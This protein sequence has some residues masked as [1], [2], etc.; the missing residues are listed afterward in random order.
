M[1]DDQRSLD[2]RCTSGA[3]LIRSISNIVVGDLFAR[4]QIAGCP[5]PNVSDLCDVEDGYTQ[6]DHR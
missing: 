2:S 4:L 6:A 5:G 1:I 3:W